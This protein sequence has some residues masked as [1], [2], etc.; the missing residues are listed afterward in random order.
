VA[1]LVA[2][3]LHAGLSGPRSG[4]A[5]AA[6][7]WLMI[8]PA[9]M[10]SA[11]YLV[12][13]SSDLPATLLALL[14][15]WRTFRLL[16][17]EAGDA[18]ARRAELRDVTL[19]A[20]ACVCVKVSALVFAAGV[21]LVAAAE[22]VR[23]ARGRGAPLRRDAL[24]AAAIAGALLLPWLARGAVLSGY[25]L[26]PLTALAL[27]V[28]WRVPAAAAESE[29]SGVRAWAR[30]PGVPRELVL[31]G[32]Y[33]LES[34][35]RRHLVL[36][37]GVGVPLPLLLGGA[38]LFLAALGGSLG[39]RSRATRALW[40][41]APAAVALASWFWMAPDPRFAMFSL[42][43]IAAAGLG[44]AAGVW[45]GHALGGR[46]VAGG[47]A[48]LAVGLSLASLPRDGIRAGS[49]GGFHALP[50]V[51]TERFVTAS[52]LAVNVPVGTDQCWRAEQPCTPLR[53]A[54]LRLRREG[55]PR[56]GFSR[57]T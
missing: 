43:S 27:P 9:F 38:G 31:H 55:D 4:R 51:R 32:W 23:D 6:F 17:G 25:P 30:V 46:L 21:W 12:S 37:V 53:R 48:A 16:A 35:G 1:A 47:V 29:A 20:A 45:S 54:E 7:A 33:W 22:H 44:T 15:A 50:A 57:G 10:L 52:G 34:W 13:L 3:C 5:G 36:R 24:A 8:P 11:R 26:Y 2:H 19:L 49:E 56:R 39:Q 42:W 14:V 18:L 41:L 28:D 40:L